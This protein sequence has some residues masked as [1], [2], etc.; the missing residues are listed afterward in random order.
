[1]CGA[2][3]LFFFYKNSLKLQNSSTITKYYQTFFF[4]NLS[5]NTTCYIPSKSIFLVRGD[6]RPN[7]NKWGT[8]QTIT[9]LWRALLC[10]QI[11]HLMMTRLTSLPAFSSASFQCFVCNGVPSLSLLIYCGTSLLI[12]YKCVHGSI[13]LSIMILSMNILP[14]TAS[15][16][17]LGPVLSVCPPS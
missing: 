5:D 9:R 7:K 6:G 4:S 11:D 8:S 1:M 16:H 12:T 3:E 10:T 2:G 13:L 15:V 14:L 17:A